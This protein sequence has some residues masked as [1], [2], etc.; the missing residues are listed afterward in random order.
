M[1]CKNKTKE[2]SGDVNNYSNRG[3]LLFLYPL[4][5]IGPPV[6]CRKTQGPLRVLYKKGGQGRIGPLSLK[7]PSEE[8]RKCLRADPPPVLVKVNVRGKPIKYTDYF[9]TIN[10]RSNPFRL[11]PLSTYQMQLGISNWYP[12]KIAMSLISF[13]RQANKR[14]VT[15][16]QLKD[17]S[18]KCIYLF[19]IG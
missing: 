14:I 13:F 5:P 6:I 15:R 4:R 17:I 12:A 3:R 18:I 11:F 10:A 9:L 1:F 2:K 7:T 8:K 16:L 19:I